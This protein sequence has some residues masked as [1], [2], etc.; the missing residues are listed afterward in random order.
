MGPIA[1]FH[2][3]R[4]GGVAR[5]LGRLGSDRIRLRDVDGLLFWRLLGTGGGARTGPGADL[6]RSAFVAVWQTDAALDRF[7]AAG[8]FARRWAQADEHWQARLRSLGGHGRW[9]GFPLADRVVPGVERGPV[10]VLTRA[11]VRAGAWRAFRRASIAADTELRRAS[12]LIDVVG[13]GETPV[14]RLGTFSLWRSA[15]DLVSYATEMPIHRAV[16]RRAHDQGWFRES[17]FARF[18]PYA[19]AG[20]WDGRDPLATLL[21]P[22]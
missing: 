21:A 9:N 16:A 6:G 3:I 18:E 22:R 11:T 1:S 12:G 19:S 10:I 8:P 15:D 5:T 2:L 13:I 4:T 7:L 20:E 14:G 17:L